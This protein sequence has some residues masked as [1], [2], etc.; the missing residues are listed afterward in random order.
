MKNVPTVY[1][2]RKAGY[3]VKINHRRVFFR[4]DVFTGKK[5][6]QLV[7]WQDKPEDYFVQA[8][9]GSTTIEL[10]TPDGQ[11]ATGVSVCSKA[12]HFCRKIGIK[13]ALARTLGQLS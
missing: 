8:T 13:K 7:Q 5:N 2:L 10:T 6:T 3:Q 4:H 11:V 1:E 12:E 9:G